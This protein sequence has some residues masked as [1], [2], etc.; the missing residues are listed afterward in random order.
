MRTNKDR[1]AIIS[2]E[3][4][5]V[6]P[7]H[8]GHHGVDS[9]GVPFLLPGTG[10]IT[11]N[12]KVGDPAFGWAGDHLEPGVST[13]LDEEKRQSYENR[14]YNFI[15]CIGNEAKVMS[16]EAKGAVGVVTGHHGGAEHVLMDFP[17]DALENLSHKDRIRIKGWGQGLR[18]LDWA[19]VTCYNLSPQLLEKMSITET[20]QGLEIGVTAIIPGH[21]MGSGVGSLSMGSGDYDIMTTDKEQLKQHN[22]GGLCFGDIVAITDHDNIYGR[23]YRKGAVTIGVII[24]SDCRYAGHGP[25][26]VTMIAS[27]DGTII[28]VIKEKQNLADYFGIG[29]K[30]AGMPNVPWVDSEKKPKKKPTRRYGRKKR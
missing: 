10:G 8:R 18:F 14:G 24:H 27:P 20:K 22:L 19:K 7:G 9:E 17:D 5:V 2:V 30:R 13:I 4:H 15:A 3:G 28:P 16:G 11:F 12:I 26:V 29:R 1:L 25:G 6:N 21:L 23:S